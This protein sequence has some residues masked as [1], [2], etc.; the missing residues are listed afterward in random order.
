ML[1]TTHKILNIFA[2]KP[3][4]KHTFK[5]IKK[6]SKN[7]SDS[8]IYNTLKKFVKTEILQQET[9]GKTILYSAKKTQ[10]AT[11]WL[12]WA[13]E[14]TAW[15]QKHIPHKQIEKIIPK[16]PTNFFTLIITGSYAKKQQKPESDIDIVILCDKDPQKVYAEIRQKCE[17]SIPEI[18]PYVFTEKE[19]YKMLTNKEPNYGKETVN[20]NF[21]LTGGAAY[22]QILFEAISNGF[23]S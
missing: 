21:I 3:W 12:Q 2:E 5:Q 20:N 15:N 18:H 13:S 11:A 4:K 9:A 19:F 23:N 17:L 16:I 14:Y 8:Y 7:K 10:K 22:Y 6:L 1:K